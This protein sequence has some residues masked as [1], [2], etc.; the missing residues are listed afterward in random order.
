MIIY[1]H[2]LVSRLL[3]EEIGIFDYVMIVITPFVAIIGTFIV[4]TLTIKFNE[5]GMVVSYAMV[6]PRI[7]AFEH[8]E[9]YTIYY[10]NIDSILTFYP[11]WF[12]IKLFMISYRLNEKNQIIFMSNLMCNCSD[13][14][15]FLLKKVNPN[16]IEDKIRKKYDV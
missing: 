10:K 2:D 9:N 7:K 6:K 11:I 12:P 15:L 13:E 14:F 16:V 1:Y 8:L 5:D 3:N 4:F